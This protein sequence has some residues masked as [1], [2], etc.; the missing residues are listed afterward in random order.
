M[1]CNKEEGVRAKE[2]VE[3]KMNSKDYVGARRMVVKAQKLYPG[4]EN[5]SQMLTVCEVHCSAE[6]RV[7]GSDPDWYDILQI[8]QTADEASIKKQFRKLALQLHPDKNKFPGAEAAFKL[9][10]EAQ[11]LLCDQSKRSQFD[12]KRNTMRPGQQMQSQNHP[13]R[14]NDSSKQPGMHSN[15]SSTGAAAQFKSMNPHQQKQQQIP[16]VYAN[17]LLWTVCPFCSIRYHRDIMN[18]A[19]R[20][21]RCMKPFIANNLN[22]QGMASGVNNPPSPQKNDL[23]KRGM[24]SGVNNLPSPQKKKARRGGRKVAP[25]KMRGKCGNVAPVLQPPKMSGRASVAGRAAKPNVNEDVNVRVEAGKKGKCILAEPKP[26]GTKS[27]KRGRNSDPEEVTDS[28]KT[29]SSCDREEDGDRKAGQN[30]GLNS[31]H[32]TRRSSR[33]KHDVSYKE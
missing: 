5:I 25:V 15:P 9:I 32:H 12:M 26:Q 3:K 23:N 13:S 4:I 8:E 10:E 30:P 11:R 2:L 21:R 24:P 19:P 6:C 14:S 31:G 20:C 22:K 28:F 16:P 33:L 17:S 1:E 7:L 18:R 29:E 27:R